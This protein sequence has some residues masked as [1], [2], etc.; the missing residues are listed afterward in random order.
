LRKALG[1]NFLDSDSEY[2]KYTSDSDDGSENISDKS[3]GEYA[4]DMSDEDFPV[5]R[6]K[7]FAGK[8]GAEQKIIVTFSTAKENSNIDS[9]YRIEKG[10]VCRDVSAYVF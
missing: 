9:N 3:C 1:A 7:R 6:M 2:E 4:S 10:N 8:K 5:R